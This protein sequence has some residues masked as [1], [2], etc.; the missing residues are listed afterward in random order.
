MYTSKPWQWQGLI[1]LTAFEACLIHSSTSYSVQNAA[2]FT[3]CSDI[4]ARKT[5]I[6]DR[7]DR[8]YDMISSRIRAKF[9]FTEP[10]PKIVYR[11]W[12]WNLKVVVGRL[13][14][15][16][17]GNFS[18]AMLTFWGVSEKSKFQLSCDGLELWPS[19]SGEINHFHLQPQKWLPPKQ[20]TGHWFWKNV[21]QANITPH[22]CLEMTFSFWSPKNQHGIWTWTTFFKRDSRED[23]TIFRLPSFPQFFHGFL[24]L[25]WSSS[26]AMDSEPAAVATKNMRGQFRQWHTKYCWWRKS[27][28]SWQVVYPII[29]MVLHIPGGARFLSS[30]VW[31]IPLPKT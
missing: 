19:N 3:Q 1:W 18:R 14:S 20:V 16:W 7:Y 23:I 17:E 11:S 24:F 13:F 9:H 29:Y 21:I 15:F 31:V 5:T 27:C 4:F 30:T 25:A 22:N 2:R 6:P 28:T 8:Y 26:T 10:L 12:T